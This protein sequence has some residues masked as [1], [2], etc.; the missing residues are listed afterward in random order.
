MQGITRRS[1]SKLNLGAAAFAALAPSIKAFAAGARHPLVGKPWPGWKPGEFQVHFIYTGVAESAFYIFP[2][3]TTMLLD[4]GD[5]PAIT[6]LELAV[7]VKPGPQRLA[8]DWIARYVQRVN[9]NGA[10]VD[11]MELSHWHSDHGGTPRWVSS[12]REGYDRTS[13]CFRSG[14]ALA[15]ETLHFRRAI[16]RGWPDYD[17]PMR[18]LPPEPV[19]V[20]DHMKRLYAWLGRRDG[21]EVEKFRLG[22]RDQV[23]P[24][25]NPAAAK[26]F[27]VFNLCAN[28]KYVRKDGTVR[29]I[30]AEH[31]ASA[32]PAYLNENGMSLG[33]IFTYGKFRLY[34]AGDF[35]DVLRTPSGKVMTEDL[36]AEALPKVNVAKAN[37]HAHYAMPAKLVAALAPQVWTIC[38]W[39]QLH[40][41]AG[42]MARMADRS[43]YPGERVLC[44]GI[45]PRE[46]R[47][48]DAGSPWLAAVHASAFE[49]GHVVVNVAPGGDTYTVSYL[50][51][52][53]E[54]M[55]VRSVLKFDC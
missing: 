34:T 33:H 39:D 53:D 28:G 22:A 19:N 27:E 15:A 42:D 8:G 55:T 1:F 35:S 20:L 29:D 26:G 32:K 49:G 17:E 45:F 37:H 5:H 41:I 44:P 24:L 54:S 47:D 13:G 50:T 10:N 40:S 48:E 6:R 46:R 25:R 2:D 36:L 38:V 43:L 14:F 51:A 31:I 4:C 12:R 18:G 23:V 3:G 52:E 9:P 11:Y 30:Y 7:P 21:L 16:D